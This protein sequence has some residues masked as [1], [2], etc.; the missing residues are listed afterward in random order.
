M[1]AGNSDAAPGPAAYARP[2]DTGRFG[3]RGWSLG[4]FAGEFVVRCPRCGSA[5]TVRRDWDHAARAW[6]PAAVVC[7]GCGFSRR[8]R[9]SAGGVPDGWAGPVVVRVRRRCGA[10]GR[11]MQVC[12]RAT[13]VPQHRSVLLTCDGCGATTHAGY[14]LSP[15]T[16]PD[17]LVDNCFGLPLWLR[18]PCA[19]RVLWA[20]NGRHLAYLRAYL[21]ADLRERRNAPGASA[22]S[23]L[24]GWLKQARH[25]GEA[26]R[27][28]ER[29]E[30]LLPT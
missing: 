30:R 7:A 10:C 19:G 9:T 25:R 24:P 28:V 18:T 4:G 5:A 1:P 27:A 11:R 6:R 26:L 29:L 13:A 8:Q 20:F 15:L 12:R 2:V 14:E 16:V 21:R 22:V 3:D 23:R 17:A